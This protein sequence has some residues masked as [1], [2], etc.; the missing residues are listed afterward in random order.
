M[1]NKVYAITDLDGY[2]SQMRKE[3]AKNISDSYENDNL[4]EYISLNQMIGLVDAH[5]LGIDEESR[6]LLDEDS[7]ED[8]FNEVVIWIHNAGLAKLASQN[9]VECAWDDDTNQMIFWSKEEISH[10]KKKTRRSPR[11]KNLGSKKR[12]P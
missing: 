6:Y 1:S 4:D 5:S 12:D 3:A 2:V 11:R 8:I 10:E 7:N 9:L